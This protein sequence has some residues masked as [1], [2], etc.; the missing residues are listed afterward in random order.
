MPAVQSEADT[1]RAGERRAELIARALLT[2]GALIPYWPLLT[3]AVVFV[4]DD[5]F[6]SDIFNGE[7]PGRV[8]IGEM[9]RQGELPIWTSRLCSGIVLAGVSEPIGLAS[10]AALPPAAALDVFLIVM[11]LVAA[12]GA[13]SLARR[14]DASRPGA[15]LAGIAFAGSG[16]FAAQ[17]KHLAI[18]STVVWLPV[19][20]VCLDRAFGDARD[21]R[22]PTML[23][24][25]FFV[26]AFGLVFA[27]QVLSGFPQS[28]YI[29]GVVYGAFALFRSWEGRR[30]F[31]SLQAPLWLMAASGVAV[32][33][34]GA[35]GAVSWLPLLE[36]GA[37]SDRN[38]TLGW[39]WSTTV[40]YWP[41]NALTFLAP[42]INGDVSNNT[43]QGRS[44]FWED[45]GYVG[46]ATFL[47]AVYGAAREWRRPLVAFAG[48]MTVI[49]YFMVLG[50]SSY[51]FWLAYHVLPGLSTFRFP[52]RFLIVVDLGL[53]LLAA[54]GLTR[55]GRELEQRVGPRMPIVAPAVVLGLCMLTVADLFLHQPRQNP[56]VD[57]TTWLQ[58]PVT[59]QHV[60]A[61]AA[62][63][64]T[65]TVGHGILHRLAFQEARGWANLA[66]YFQLRDA[67]QPN[68]GAFWNTPSAD[69]Y[70]GI[71][72]S[73]HVDVWGD[74]NRPGLVAGR[75]AGLDLNAGALRVHPEIV[76]VLGAYG[77]THVVSAFPT[78]AT[79]PVPPPQAAGSVHVYPIA[80]AARVR[81]VAAARHVGN[82]EDAAVRLLDEAF[83]PDREVLLHDAPPTIAP[84]VSEGT[85]L[86]SATG[87]RARIVS[88][89][90]RE[91]VVDA[92]TD[93]DAFL[94]L[95]DSFYPGW[96][97]Q[98][99]GHRVPLYRANVSV[100]GLQLP[101]GQ[102]SVRFVYEARSYVQGL[103]V[104]AVALTCLVAWMG[105][106]WF[107]ERR[108]RR[109]GDIG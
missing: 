28:A 101:K 96:V 1:S 22:S 75:L 49:A 76:K 7:L 69:C 99:D 55:L 93:T 64:R 71:A 52:T 47:L 5:I 70:A 40:P 63:P 80:G 13:Y 45:Y 8:L 60:Q 79:A 44:L 91:V 104:S 86:A 68:V 10:F 32:L 38:Q 35:A 105:L 27:E 62:H 37:L 59:V 20:L 16:Y 6:T 50:R 72:P 107:L 29:C 31:G 98:I 51:V 4:T 83:D 74:H 30:R 77:V 26:G 25:L 78:A 108:S 90:A 89:S 94:V 95:A 14:M 18:V 3:L 33:L 82:N 36:L 53:A 102:H 17:L 100:R 2:I 23:R 85:P 57:A 65:F 46:V 73:W 12:H 43:Y 34:G 58:P 41:W 19:A 84:T 54:V 21:G 42:Y 67:L 87:G 56:M 11:L 48:A 106:A 103:T 88:E 24:R 66:P 97:A 109:S 81:V 9:I 92:A 15:V 61:G 39:L